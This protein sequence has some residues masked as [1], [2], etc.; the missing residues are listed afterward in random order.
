LNV[1][2]EMG[3]FLPLLLLPVLALAGAATRA[4]R[5][6]TPQQPKACGGAVLASDMESWTADHSVSADFT[7]DGKPDVAFWRPDSCDLQH[8]AVEAAGLLLD[9]TVVARACGTTPPSSECLY[10]RKENER[11]QAVMDAGGRQLHV[12]APGCAGTRLRWASDI[13][14]FMKIPG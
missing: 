14:G 10:L 13:G 9:H 6:S 2:G 8:V 1:E 5:Q 7:L 4:P 3:R 11:R 12:Y